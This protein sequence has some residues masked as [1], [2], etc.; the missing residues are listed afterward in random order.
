[1][2]PFFI[3]FILLSLLAS[4]C[5]KS[6]YDASKLNLD[7]EVVENGMSLG[8]TVGI[9]YNWCFQQLAGLYRFFGFHDY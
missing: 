8:W 1:M 4:G 5:N 7:F 9:P 3:V 2:R 6:R